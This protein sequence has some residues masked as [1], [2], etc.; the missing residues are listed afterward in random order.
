LE[1]LANLPRTNTAVVSI[2]SLK[3]S[4]A[5]DIFAYGSVLYELAT[6]RLPFE[7]VEAALLIKKVCKGERA[8]LASRIEWCKLTTK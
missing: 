1:L 6:N 8:S 5:T 4:Y 3:Y 2:H 7:D